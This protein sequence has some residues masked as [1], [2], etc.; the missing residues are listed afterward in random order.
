MR[1]PRGEREEE[2]DEERR[3]KKKP[4]GIPTSKGQRERQKIR[5][6]AEH[7]EGYMRGTKKGSETELRREDTFLMDRLVVSGK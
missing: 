3:M 7:L 4:Y 1:L 6:G 5:E 2:E